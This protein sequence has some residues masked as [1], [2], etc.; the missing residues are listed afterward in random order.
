MMIGL[1]G[2]VA[3]FILSS[4][5]IVWASGLR[6]NPQTWGFEK[7]VLVA[8]EGDLKSVAIKVNNQLIS[9]SLPVRLRNLLPGRYDVEIF[10]PKFQSYRRV[11]QL[12]EN[13]VGI[14]RDP[15]LIASSPLTT[16]YRQ[17][18]SYSDEVRFDSGLTETNN[19]L[20]DQGVLVS[21]FSSPVIQAH[22]Y[23][24]GYLYQLGRQLRLAFPEEVQDFF[25]YDLKSDRYAPLRVEESTWQIIVLDGKQTQLINLTLP[26]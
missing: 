12:S 13:Q 10:K 20:R 19:E 21:R 25:V 23:N 17:R 7:T 8:I 11:F 4:A 26:R 6:F 18:I 9:R 15:T 14:I 1:L 2:I 22:R 3:F 5:A 24:N 16:P